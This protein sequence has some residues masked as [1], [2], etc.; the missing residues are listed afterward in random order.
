MR[1]FAAFCVCFY[2]L[3][4]GLACD[5]EME[6][7]QQ[8][9]ELDI[10]VWDKTGLKSLRPVTGGVPLSQGVAPE[11]T[12]FI[13]Y[14][15]N[16]SRSRNPVWLKI[17]VKWAFTVRTEIFIKSAIG[18]IGQSCYLGPCNGFPHRIATCYM[19]QQRS[20]I[21]FNIFIFAKPF[22]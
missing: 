8:M 11:G 20:N 21:I 12:N 16:S 2:F 13:L 3:L 15:E 14:D 1:R 18:N 5:G 9:K 17:E 19:N 6:N 4:T 7:I 10:S 22:Y